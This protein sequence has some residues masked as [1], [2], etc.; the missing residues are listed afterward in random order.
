MC[1]RVTKTSGRGAAP[2]P[3][4]TFRAPQGGRPTWSG[5]GSASG[6]ERRGCRPRPPRPV[7]ARQC[8]TARRPAGRRTG[9]PPP[10]SGARHPSGTG[11]LAGSD[12]GA[13]G[14]MGCP[15]PSSP[16]PIEHASIGGHSQPRP[17]SADRHRRS[18]GRG[19]TEGAP[20]TW[21]AGAVSGRTAISCPATLEVNRTRRNRHRHPHPAVITGLA[22]SPSRSQRREVVDR[23]FGGARPQ[24]DLFGKSDA[25]ASLLP[26]SARER[27]Y[28]NLTSLFSSAGSVTSATDGIA[29]ISIK[30]CLAGAG[31]QLLETAW[32][33]NGQS[34][35]RIGRAELDRRDCPA[36]GA[37]LGSAILNRE[38]NRSSTSPSSC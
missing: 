22:N 26:M 4:T 36:G 38:G 19:A 31:Q 18:A 28:A 7:L 32:Y 16:M 30:Y 12:P 24:G 5:P 20:A 23:R 29:R 3:R 21:T 34:T 27:R 17:R 1:F 2:G 11:L 13:A 15:A 37:S 8:R 10:G 9:P 35:E 33:T 14:K 25:V 6:A